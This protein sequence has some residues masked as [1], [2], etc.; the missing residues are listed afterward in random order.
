MNEIRNK[1]QAISRLQE[2][3]KNMQ[4]YCDDM[5]KTKFGCRSCIFH[6]FVCD[7]SNA[8]LKIHHAIG[9]LHGFNK[10]DDVLRYQTI[11]MIDEFKDKIENHINRNIAKGEIT[12]TCNY[13]LYDL[14]LRIFT[15]NYAAP[16]INNI[17]IDICRNI[18]DEK[19][20]IKC[21]WLIWENEKH[22][23]PQNRIGLIF[24]VKDDKQIV[25]ISDADLTQF[26]KQDSDINENNA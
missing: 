19:K 26:I 13:N 9:D 5:R 25:R 6:D 10:F 3:A 7:L 21:G 20:D 18:I 12:L 16:A 24:F 8:G 4:A 17:P 11:D 23:L 2:I 22:D 15:I 1:E 14:F